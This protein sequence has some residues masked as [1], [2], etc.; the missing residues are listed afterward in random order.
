MRVIVAGETLTGPAA[1]ARP[2]LGRKTR[3]AFATAGVLVLGVAAVVVVGGSRWARGTGEAAARLAERTAVRMPAVAFSELEA[4][5]A[6]VRRYLRLAL[7]DGQPRIANVRLRQAGRLRTGVESDQWLE[8]EATETIAPEAPGFVWD[9]RIR[10][11]PFVHAAMRDTYIAATGSGA[12][13]LQSAFTLTAQSGGHELDAGNLYRLLAEAAWAPTLLLPRDGLTW[14][15]IDDRRALAS[16]TQ[17]RETATVEFRF[18]DAGEIAAIHA[19]ERP[20]SYGTTYVPTPWEGHFDRYVTVDGMRVPQ[21]G[22]VGW[23]VE[24][25]WIPVWRATVTDFE[26]DYARR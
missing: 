25:R 7:R 17:G 13:A 16:L 1:V 20:R 4:L 3:I 21:G 23:W 14:A 8:F 26:F 9:A 24:D 18:N 2:P 19:A 11:L 5:P 10:L 15:R 6:P 12:V 22:E